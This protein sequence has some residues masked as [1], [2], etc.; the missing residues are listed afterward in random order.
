MLTQ[1]VAQYPPHHVTNAPAKFEV[2]T[3][4][5][6]GDAFTRKSDLDLGIKVILNIALGPLHHVTYAPAKFEVSM[7][8]FF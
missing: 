1:N 5:G 6:L 2:A 8:R 4:K 3:S 7:R